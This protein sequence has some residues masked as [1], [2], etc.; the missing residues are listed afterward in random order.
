MDL[1]QLQGVDDTLRA[2]TNITKL[3]HQAVD[4]AVPMKK[5]RQTEAPWWN[6]SLT[7]A[8]LSAKRAD[9]RA[10]LQPSDTN[11]KDS[12]H[13]RHKWSVMVR[14]AKTAYRVQQLESSSTGTVWKTI[15][16]HN[17]HHKPI[18]PLEG[19]TDFQGKCDVL[20]AALFPSVNS[21]H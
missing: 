9:R 5:S 3:I 14:N 15:E 19:K 7:L 20:R 13:K 6:H 16:H 11:Q 12:Q 21:D 18:P 10:W 1:S 17:T 8:K 2:I 4:E